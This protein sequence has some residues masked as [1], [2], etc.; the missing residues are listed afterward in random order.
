MPGQGE[1]EIGAEP[2]GPTPPLGPE[3]GEPPAGGAQ[4]GPPMPPPPNA[5]GMMPPV[6]QAKPL[7]KFSDKD[8]VKYDMEIQDYET[9][10]DTE[11]IDYTDAEE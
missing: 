8:A 5:P 9:E 10:Q 2:G 1:P 3:G 7:P 6:E 4:G 11:N